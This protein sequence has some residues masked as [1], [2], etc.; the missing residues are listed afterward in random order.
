MAAP[1]NISMASNRKPSNRNSSIRRL[2]ERRRAESDHLLA[3]LR[4]AKESTTLGL[5]VVSS[6]HATSSSIIAKTLVA[7]IHRSSIP[8]RTK[9]ANT[10][11]T[12]KAIRRSLIK[13]VPKTTASTRIR[14][15]AQSIIIT[16]TGAAI[17]ISIYTQV[18]RSTTQRP[19]PKTTTLMH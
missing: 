12:K 1:N 8:F 4:K 2:D 3:G 13:R 10:L 6:I 14:S 9:S 7:K 5:S 11:T 19:Q 18:S 17:T 15:Q 16:R